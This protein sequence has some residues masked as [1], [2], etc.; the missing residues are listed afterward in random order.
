MSA[1]ARVDAAGKVWTSSQQRVVDDPTLRVDGRQV[2]TWAEHAGV[3]VRPLLRQVTDRDTGDVTRVPIPC[4]STR[5]KVC[6]P[7]ADK[8]RRVRQQQCREGWHRDDEPDTD[9]VADDLDDGRPHLDEVAEDG[10]TDQADDER[11]DRRT[12]STRRRD[13]AA[14]LPRVPQEDRTVGRTWT[15]RDGKVYRP[16]MF[17]TLT[18]PSYGRVIPGTGTPIDA[19]SYDYRRAALDAI[20]LPRLLARWVQNL[21]RCAGYRAQYF[22]AIEPQKRLAPHVHFAIRGAVPRQVLRD[23]TRA[24]YVQVWWPPFDHVVYD[25]SSTGLP[26]WDAGAYRDPL[27]GAPLPTW[28]EAMDDL[29]AQL[30][31]DPGQPAG[32]TMRFGRQTDIKGILGDSADADRTIRYLTKYLTKSLADL[33]TDHNQLEDDPVDFDNPRSARTRA[34]MLAS[35]AAFDTHVD[36]LHE[37]VRWLPCSPE[38]ANWLRHGIQPKDC[39]PGMEPGACEKRA[40]DRDNL[41]YGGRRVQVSKQWSGKTLAEHRAD[42]ATVVRQTLLAAGIAP[43]DVDRMAVDAVLDDGRPRFVW[44]DIPMPEADYAAAILAAVQERNRW[45]EQYEHAKRQ[46]DPGGTGPPGRAVDNPLSNPLSGHAA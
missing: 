33:F 26:V 32:H 4:K 42:R 41:G 27:N 29:D 25:A 22:A 16:S 46:L 30:D 20:H 10:A 38:C 43:P 6:P 45:R 35:R 40:H 12:R 1:L 44:A 5:D 14:D 13:D 28:D 3:C 24:T 9:Q 7:C 31:A 11:T 39:A 36:R 17:V 2:R 34:R 19:E 37:E 8:A 15:G 18:L 23:V 21:R